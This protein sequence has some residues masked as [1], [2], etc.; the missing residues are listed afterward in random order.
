V[1]PARPTPSRYTVVHTCPVCHSRR[2]A[3][4]VMRAW[5]CRTCVD[6]GLSGELI[7]TRVDA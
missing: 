4:R 2:F 6:A 5:R 1:K 7:A 3:R